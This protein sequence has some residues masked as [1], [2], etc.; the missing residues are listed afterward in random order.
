MESLVIDSS[1]WLNKKVLVTG[2][3]GFK[4]TWLTVLLKKLGASVYGIS[5]E[6]EHNSIANNLEIEDYCENFNNDIRDREKTLNIISKINPQ[7]IFH[8]AAQSLVLRS[9]SDPYLTYSSN[10]LGLVNILDAARCSK[11]C[12]T[13]INVTSDKCYKNLESENGYAETDD[14]GGHDPY[15]NSKACSEL[16]TDS[17]RASFFNENNI[18]CITARAGNVIGGGDWAENRL[19]PDIFRSILSKSI[20]SIRNPNA[21]RPWQHVLEPLGGYIHLAQLS[22]SSDNYSEPWNFGPEKDNMR[23]V[24]D[25]LDE[26][27]LHFNLEGKIN[28]QKNKLHETQI[29]KLDITKSKSKL[30]WKPQWDF[31]KTIKLTCEWYKEYMNSN[32][33]KEITD[34]HIKLYLNDIC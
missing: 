33:I 9:Y 31:K 15:S 16:V 10:I 34:K 26:I 21:I 11:S 30:L 14:L 6:A 17:Y 4:G 13:I 24:Q 20:V 8:L 5:L 1:F 2:H 25:V 22:Y 7:I 29:L 23:S 3:N 12:K 28:I 27:S 32:N 19:V 18:S